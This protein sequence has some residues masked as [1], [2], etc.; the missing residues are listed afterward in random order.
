MPV[1]T[2]IELSAYSPSLKGE[3]E[4]SIKYV[5]IID[6]TSEV[7]AN[8]LVC[9]YPFDYP[10]VNN[11]SVKAFFGNTDPTYMIFMSDTRYMPNTTYL[12]IPTTF[13]ISF[14]INLDN[15]GPMNGPYPTGHSVPLVCVSNNLMLSM[16]TNGYLSNN[17]GQTSPVPVPPNAFSYV[18][19]VYSA[20][21]STMYLYSYPSS[22]TAWTD[23]SNITI[24]TLPNVYM[25]NS[26]FIAYNPLTSPTATPNNY[27][28]GMVDFRLYSRALSSSEISQ[29]YTQYNSYSTALA[30][31]TSTTEIVA[32]DV[33]VTGNVVA[34]K[35]IGIGTT[36]PK[37]NLD[38][39]GTVNVSG[40]L[41][42]S[43]TA[44]P[45]FN[46]PNQVG[47]TLSG[48]FVPLLP[49]TMTSNSVTCLYMLTLPVGI[50]SLNAQVAFFTTS[51]TAT[52]TAA[53]VS[54]SDSMGSVVSTFA[55]SQICSTI[56]IGTNTN[57]GYCSN[58]SQMFSNVT[59]DKS[60]YLNAQFSGTNAELANVM[61]DATRSSFTATRI[62]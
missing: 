34:L 41:S 14:W 42:R 43:Y 56:T 45:L 23:T 58:V 30:I 9:Y 24:D 16:D 31:P 22:A 49:L 10:S 5:N 15:T 27:R 4:S 55:C 12:Y 39:S 21:V 28:F 59:T 3:V 61:L 11:L 38:V 32:G 8:S 35:N 36:T 33:G 18:S 62:A 46:N 53:V 20:G 26:V 52:V 6:S 2:N 40:M 25:P 7:D 48:T 13:T 17:F 37:Y 57:S 47:Y 19:W 29:L 50:W 60:F 44:L 51:G 54:M 1:S